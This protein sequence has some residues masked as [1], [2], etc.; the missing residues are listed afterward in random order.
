MDISV[1]IPTRGRPEKLAAC[2]TALA[3]QNYDPTRYEVLV[4]IDGA[5]D[6]EVHAQAEAGFGHLR[7]VVFELP[8]G[9]ISATRNALLPHARGRILLFMN[10]DVLATPDLLAAHVAAHDERARAGKPAAMIQGSTP[11]V[12]PGPGEPD[13]LFDR[14]IRETSMI[15]FYDQMVGP[16]AEDPD[17][18]WGFRHAWPLN[19]SVAAELVRAVGGFTVFPT[20]YGLEDDEFA[21]RLRERFGT[22]VLFRPRALAWHDHRYEPGEYLARERKLG[23]AAWGFA[24]VSPRCAMAMFGR[25]IRSAEE[26]AYSR[27]YV[28]RERAG[29]E[30]AREAFHG[31]VDI[32]AGAV[33]GEHQN[34]LIRLIYQQ[35]LPLK[36]WEWRMGLLAAAGA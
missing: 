26:V 20:P 2:L 11:F 16:R 28:E 33:S 13:R 27:A 23:E 18:D 32:P 19:L 22:P 25:D 4:G 34:E 10:D 7:S 17:H 21:F 29:V 6:G 3:R 30:R 36:R 14:L 12:A 24:G 15:F 31:L 9:G 8:R 5:E 35:H 1:I